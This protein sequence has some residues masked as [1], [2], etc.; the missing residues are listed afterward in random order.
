MLSLLSRLLVPLFILAVL[1]IALNVSG[2]GTGGVVQHNLDTVTVFLD[3]MKER[4]DLHLTRMFVSDE[5]VYHVNSEGEV[6]DQSEGDET[7]HY[8]SVSMVD[9]SLPLSRIQNDKETNGRVVC[10][11]SISLKTEIQERLSF[12]WKVSDKS[13]TMDIEQKVQDAARKRAEE[14]VENEGIKQRAEENAI[15]FFSRLFAMLGETS[16][17]VKFCEESPLL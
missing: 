5:H 17:D 11:P 3:T 16:V 6:V 4:D 8:V 1:L 10:L 7:V 13:S 9:A 12:I 2:F 15:T 14:K